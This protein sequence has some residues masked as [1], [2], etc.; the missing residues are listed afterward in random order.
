M[1]SKTCCPRQE[2]FL[3][4]LLYGLGWLNSGSQASYKESSQSSEN[5]TAILKIFLKLNEARPG[6]AEVGEGGVLGTLALS[7]IGI[8]QLP[9][10]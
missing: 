1:V 6:D 5:V 7:L 8:E 10:L 9:V 2:P 3:W 4:P